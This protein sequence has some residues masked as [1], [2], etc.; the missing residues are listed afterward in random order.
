MKIDNKKIEEINRKAKNLYINII[1]N[2]CFVNDTVADLLKYELY[3]KLCYEN[4]E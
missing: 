2:K 1:S 3:V 4:D